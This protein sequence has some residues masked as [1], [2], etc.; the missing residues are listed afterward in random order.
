MRLSS[1]IFLNVIVL[2]CFSC[3]SS[4]EEATNELLVEENKNYSQAGNELSLIHI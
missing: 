3:A 2:A 4:I 1:K